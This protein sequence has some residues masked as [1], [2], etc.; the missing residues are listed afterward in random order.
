MDQ[1]TLPLSE[2]PECVAINAVGGDLQVVGWDRTDVQAR[3]DGKLANLI[4]IG[5]EVQVT[6]DSDLILYIPSNSGLRINAIGGDADVRMVAGKT[7][8]GNVGGD[9]QLRETGPIKLGS[10]GGD[11]SAKRTQGDLLAQNIGGDASLRQVSG[12]VMIRNIGSDF[13]L[14][15]IGGSVNVNT[16]SDA[17]IYAQPTAAVEYRV[18]A[19]SD[20][21]LRVPL[22]INATLELIGGGDDSVRVRLPNISTVDGG[23]VLGLVLGSGDAKIS[24]TAGDEVVVTNSDDEWKSLVA[25]D[26]SE[27]D[28]SYAGDQDTH[29]DL[30]GRISAQVDAAMRRASERV[31]RSQERAQAR[32]DAA[33][34]RAEEK[35]RAAERRSTQ[36]GVSMGRGSTSFTRPVT[37]VPPVKPNEPITDEERLTILRMLQEKKISLQDAE[38]L[39]TALDGK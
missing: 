16:G 22:D 3:T 4:Q 30:G 29:G 2:Y 33:V 19:G 8:I 17:V 6:C 12:S 10:V 34:R 14:Q 35:M 5:K 23:S 36:M 18:V 11:L 9:L 32:A 21:I 31:M 25:F 27:W 26:S 28:S 7:E 1:A 24:L 38:K 13:Y 37:P 20:I 39:L 15:G